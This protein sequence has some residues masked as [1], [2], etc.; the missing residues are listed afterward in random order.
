MKTIK[1]ITDDRG[2]EKVILDGVEY[3]KVSTLPFNTESY[4]MLKG[5]LYVR[6]R[7]RLPNR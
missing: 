4:F 1:F 6:K 7:N 2:R 3:R 5:E